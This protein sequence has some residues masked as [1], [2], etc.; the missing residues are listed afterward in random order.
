MST[1]FQFRE[2]LA[3]DKATTKRRIDTQNFLHVDDCNIS[4]AVVNSYLGKEVPN[5]IA[6]GLDPAKV[7][8]I[9][10]DPKELAKAASTFNN[11]PLMDKHI[12]VSDLDLEKPEIK[13]HLVG[14]TGTD[15][16]FKAPYLVNSLVVFTRGAIEDVEA[17]KKSELS[18]AYRYDIDMT[19][20]VSPEGESYD[21]RMTA[22]VG[23]HVALVIEGRAGSD[24]MVHDSAAELKTA[25]RQAVC[26]KISVALGMDANPEG[27]NQYSG[28]ANSARSASIKARASNKREDHMAAAKAHLAA[29]KSAPDVQHENNHAKVAMSHMRSIAG[30]HDSAPIVNP[31]I[32]QLTKLKAE[33]NEKLKAKTNETNRE[34]LDDCTSALDLSVH[35]LLDFEEAGEVTGDA[36]GVKLRRA[37]G[38]DAN[39][40]GINQYSEAAGKA[41]KKADAKT[42]SVRQYIGGQSSA[43]HE[44]ARA[45]H[46]KA[47][48]LHHK[49]AQEHLRAGNTK[50]YNAHNTE[51]ILHEETAQNHTQAASRLRRTG[52]GELIH[53]L[54][55]IG[56][57]KDVNPKSGIT[58]YGEVAYADPKNKK[59]PIDTE[60][61]VRAA[62]SYWGQAKNRNEYSEEDQ[63]AI[64]RR[65]ES[66]KQKFKIGE[67]AKRK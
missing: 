27:V 45:L 8:K 62:L 31:Y 39:P 49:A 21:G 34:V 64:T 9:Y 66:A 2:L 1:A 38:F 5:W 23:N 18:C 26:R 65:I 55:P 16:V 37:M 7:Y 56:K 36:L 17:E 25:A 32:D 59:Y 50:Q 12:E 53:D 30:A 48:E 11:L 40:E 51:A 35:H 14:S 42:R 60:A 24:V 4:K 57:R 41:T 10:R 61:H 13:E 28:A 67:N 54:P 15:A 6:L 46:E 29:A 44:Q 43:E 63:Q 52:D 22:I 20:G 58:K 33:I 47:A 3:F 19:P